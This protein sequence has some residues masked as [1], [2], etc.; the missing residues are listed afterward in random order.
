MDLD[1]IRLKVL[2]LLKDRE[3]PTDMKGAS[4]AMGRNAAYLHQFVYR[5]SPKVLSEDDRESLANHLGCEPDELKHKKT[6][7]RKP[8]KKV[9]PKEGRVQPPRASE[10]FEPARR[11]PVRTTPATAALRSRPFL[12]PHSSRSG[13]I[14][15]AT[16]LRAATS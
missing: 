13:Y 15:N 10:G 6:P 4:L 5:G 11:R 14:R 3:P 2:K 12:F 1:P 16:R 8:R 9:A 7:P